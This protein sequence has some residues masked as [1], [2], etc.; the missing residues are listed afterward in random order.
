M[1]DQRI[2]EVGGISADD[3]NSEIDLLWKEVLQPGS[4]LR[5]EAERA[6]ID[7][8]EIGDKKREE[9]ITAEQE[10][11]AFDPATIALIVAFAPLINK[12]AGDLWDRVF[13]RRIV[14]KRG[15]NALVPKEPKE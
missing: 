2:Y 15:S 14:Q 12:I 5:L 1:V 4:A 6:G 13:Y 10:G 8:A 11:S 3:L 7:V 9:V